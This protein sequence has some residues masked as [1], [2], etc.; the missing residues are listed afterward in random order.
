M[1][2]DLAHLR[3]LV[4]T[5]NHPAE[6]IARHPVTNDPIQELVLKIVGPDSEIAKLSRLKLQDDLM[7]FKG[8]PPAAEYDRMDVERLARCVVGW[9]VRS[10]TEEMAHSFSATVKLFN[11]LPFLRQQAEAFANERANFFFRMI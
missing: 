9:C 11:D 4:E 2:F 1:P 3:D 7:A 10:G 5:Q 8:R 6:M